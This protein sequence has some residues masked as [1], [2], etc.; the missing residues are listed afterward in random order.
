[1]R[2]HLFAEQAKPAGGVLPLEL[3]GQT[4]AGPAGVGVGLEE[5]EV[6]D[7]RLAEVVERTEAVQGVDAPAGVG[8]VVAL[9]VERRLPALGAHGRPALGEPELGA[10]VAVLVD[11][12]EILRAGDEARRE[13]VGREIDAVARRLVVEGEAC[14]SKRGRA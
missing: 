10:V 9:P 2:I 5:A 1:M 14:R 13:A 3:G 4:V 6:A 7:G 12:G 8:G 11:E